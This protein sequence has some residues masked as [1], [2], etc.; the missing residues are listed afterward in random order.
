MNSPIK[1]HYIPQSILARF[2]DLEGKLCTFNIKIGKR[3]KK[4]HPAGICYE[5]NL[6]TII[7]EGEKFTEIELL[8]SQIED[9]FLDLLKRV[10]EHLEK[11]IEIDYLK[12]DKDIYAILS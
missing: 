8:Y 3:G 12:E 1:H 4:R 11:S 9:K 7:H 6:H 2:C 10:D 5:E